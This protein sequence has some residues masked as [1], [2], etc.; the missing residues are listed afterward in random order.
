MNFRNLILILIFGF[1]LSSCDESLPPR[2]EPAHLLEIKDLLASQGTVPGGRAVIVV[3]IIGQNAY[4]ETFQDVVNLQG[5]ISVWWDKYPE[6]QITIPLDNGNFHKTTRFHQGVLTIDPGEEFR[7]R[8]EWY[9]FSDSGRDI[10][11][12]LDYSSSTVQ[13]N[14][15]K[16]RPEVF[17]LKAELILFENTG[18]S[19]TDSISFSFEGWKIIKDK[20]L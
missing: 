4:D 8:A 5:K 6:L 19:S 20:P 10:L 14:I 18:L 15:I 7:I 16:A 12:M 11:N 1:I 2:I 13:N 9:L 17:V 3:N